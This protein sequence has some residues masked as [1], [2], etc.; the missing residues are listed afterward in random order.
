MKLYISK[1]VAVLWE[2]A[3]LEVH[4][5]RRG[6]APERKSHM[7]AAV[8]RTCTCKAVAARALTEDLWAQTVRRGTWIRWAGAVRQLRSEV[9]GSQVCAMASRDW[10]VFGR[11][12]SAGAHQSRPGREVQHARRDTRPPQQ[13]LADQRAREVSRGHCDPRLECRIA[14][15]RP[16]NSVGQGINALVL[17]AGAW[18]SNQ[19][20]RRPPRRQGLLRFMSGSSV[21]Q[22]WRT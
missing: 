9:I 2:G 14:T 15:L 11:V 20:R 4:T 6:L 3:Q 17:R 10:Q 18:T 12:D 16:G 21:Q 22:P 13:A 1:C 7:Q 19:S 8:G 5:S